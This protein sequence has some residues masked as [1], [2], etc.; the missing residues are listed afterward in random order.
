M[1]GRR[2]RCAMLTSA[3]SRGV[4]LPQATIIGCAIVALLATQPVLSQSSSSNR[5]WGTF[6]ARYDVHTSDI[7]IYAVYGSGQSFVMAGALQN[8]RTGLT[9]LLG[10]VGRVFAPQGA[11]SHSI[12]TGIARIGNDWHAQCYYAPAVPIGRA[13]LRGT[14][15][16]DLPLTAAENA[17]I[18]VSPLSLTVP[19]RRHVEAGMSIDA[20]TAHRGLTIAGVGPEI[21]TTL[22]RATIGADVQRLVD[23]SATRLRVFVVTRF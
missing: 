18:S 20:A 11:G 23:G 12:T 4:S 22:P 19:T 8:P 5:L 6:N 15:L 10:A 14:A 13:W 17:R 9:A 16:L 7:L 3:A 21:R 1:S 2:V